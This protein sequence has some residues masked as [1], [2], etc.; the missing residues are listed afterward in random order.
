MQ[1]RK[2]K[3]SNATIVIT[4]ASNKKDFLNTLDSKVL[5]SAGFTYSHFP[6]YIEEELCLILNSRIEAF[7]PGA[8]SEEE[9]KYCAQN[10]A[11]RFHVDARR[12]ID[13]LHIA[14]K[15]ALN[16]HCKRIT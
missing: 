13:T 5:S 2:I 15:I 10:I 11:D 16:E 1:T 8:I 12:A 6:N 7:Q 4:T 9:M 3:A 14:G